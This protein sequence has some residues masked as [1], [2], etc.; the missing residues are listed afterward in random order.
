MPGTVLT[1]LSKCNTQKSS[2]YAI[3]KAVLQKFL[4]Y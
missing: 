2:T 4:Y 1:K 3:I